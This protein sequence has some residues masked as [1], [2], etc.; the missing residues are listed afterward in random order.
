MISRFDHSLLYSNEI[1]KTFQLLKN[2]F[3]LI[4]LTP[5]TNYGY[6][7]SGMFVF[8]NGILEI[9]WYEKTFVIK[10]NRKDWSGKRGQGVVG[11][12]NA[13]SK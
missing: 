6:F 2:K 4:T 8:K 9:I 1:E 13:K 5:L 10:S 11:F 12:L 3:S 7:Q